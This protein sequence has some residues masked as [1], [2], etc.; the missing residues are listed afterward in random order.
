M[1]AS[2]PDSGCPQSGARPTGPESACFCAPKAVRQDQGAGPAR[3]RGLTLVELVVVLTV[4]VALSTLVISLTSNNVAID[5]DGAGG[6]EA[7]TAQQIVTES[8]LTRIAAAIIGPDGYAQTMRDAEDNNANRIGYGTGLP[9]PSP[10]EIANGRSD[11]PQ[12]AYLFV[13]PAADVAYDPVTRIG[14]RGPWLDATTATPYAVTGTFTGLYG[15]GDGR[16]GD[17]GDDLAP[18]DGWGRPIV[19]QWYDPDGN[20]P[21]ADGDGI[22]DDPAEQA[23][24]RLVSAGPN[25]VLDMRPE[26]LEPQ[27]DDVVLYLYRN[28]GAL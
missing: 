6:T 14:W 26:D 18:L 1:M 11:H 19:I 13:P 5:I 24:A 17:T 28:S 22:I 7:K 25:R 12:L 21:D 2:L 8:T 16:G 3:E 23:T 9:W 4:L 15:E 20:G 10:A 27:Q